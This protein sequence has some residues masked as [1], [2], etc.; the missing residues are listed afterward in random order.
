MDADLGGTELLPALQYVLEKPRSRELPQQVVILTDGEVTNT[1]AVIALAR[2][3]AAHTRIF[4][5]G[6]GAGA[7]HHLVRGLARTGGGTAEFISPG[8]RIEPK[9][10]RQV[11]R[12][13]SPAL[14]NVR[15]EWNCAS[16]TQA[17]TTVPPVFANGRLTLYGFVKG[18]LP[19]S[20]RLTATSPSGPLTFDVPIPEASTSTR[21]VATLA[22]RA[23]IREL[24]EGTEWL[25]AR[26][27]QQR[28]R[29]AQARS[30]TA[31]DEII[32]L[33]IRYGL[34][35]RETSFVAV[36]RRETPVVGEVQLRRI[37]IAL[38]TGWGGVR[39]MVQPA[40][41]LRMQD[42][43]Q[44]APG[45]AMPS[46]SPSRAMAK[47]GEWVGRAMP[48]AR[49]SRPLPPA[50]IHPGVTDTQ[51]LIVLQR[52]DG[53][54]DLTPQFA[55]LIGRNY[56]ELRRALDV[57]RTPASEDQKRAWATA[58][59]IAWLERNAMD[60][61]D[62]WRMLA[63]KARRW[64]DSTNAVPPMGGRWVEAAREFVR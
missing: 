51:R 42:D 26:G 9:V 1:D 54:W 40:V 50:P 57:N 60:Q 49:S 47:V 64:L 52:A 15:V 32:A 5:F 10:L 12:L 48:G 33:S 63:D 14:T 62:E 36:E 61:Q 23:R 29:K 8:E 6:I 53:T 45:M 25:S 59:A 7:S 2:A 38:T 46:I 24:E 11:A 4:T 19:S 21:T 28:E 20:V 37:P 13:L 16:V 27:S 43:R 30:N 17:P 41:L 55:S 3:H 18:N 44:I 58:L 56:D 39:E 22:A 35:S 34:I 31:R